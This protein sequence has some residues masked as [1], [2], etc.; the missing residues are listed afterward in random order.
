MPILNYTTKVDSSKTVSEIQAILGRKGATHV[1]VDYRDGKATAIS[2]GLTLGEMPI[3]FRLP[4]NVE[5][6]SN[7]L[8]RARSHSAARRC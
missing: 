3:N 7:A 1:S 4:C 5:G 2:F 8:R 6:V